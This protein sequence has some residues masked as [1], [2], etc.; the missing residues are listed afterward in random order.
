MALLF[1]TFSIG[2]RLLLCCLGSVASPVFSLPF[3]GS[4]CSSLLLSSLLWC[5]IFSPGVYT[6]CC[7]LPVPRLSFLL[8]LGLYWPSCFLRCPALPFFCLLPFPG[9]RG[10]CFSSPGLAPLL[11]CFVAPGSLCLVAMFCSSC[12]F[13]LLTFAVASF[14]LS[15][16][17]HFLFGSTVSFCLAFSSFFRISSFVGM[18][19]SGVF[20][21]L[22]LVELLSP[23]FTWALL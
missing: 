16:L 19:S 22:S 6:Y 23:R 4:W 8:V 7:V 18:S 12:R 3:L 13:R 10:T 2:L 14:C 17:S 9:Y 11:G 20:L 1:Y 5:L 15:W 21:R